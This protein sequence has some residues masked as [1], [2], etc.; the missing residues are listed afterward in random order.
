MSMHDVEY[1]TEVLAEAVAGTQMSNEAKRAALMQLF[2]AEDRCDVGFCRISYSDALESC[3]FSVFIP[4]EDMPED[5][6]DEVSYWE[7]SDDGE[8]AYVDRT[9]DLWEELE[10]RSLL[11]PYMREKPDASSDTPDFPSYESVLYY[12]KEHSAVFS[13]AEKEN[14]DYFFSGIERTALINRL[15]ID[16]GEFIDDDPQHMPDGNAAP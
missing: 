15:P 10:K 9:F 3:G 2:A 6:A 16:V 11:T 5:L 8:Y 4:R 7:D 13:D 12:L 1:A 14:D